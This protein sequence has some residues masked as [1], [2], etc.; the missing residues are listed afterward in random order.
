[1]AKTEGVYFF[2]GKIATLALDTQFDTELAKRYALG[3]KQVGGG[4]SPS[5]S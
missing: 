5:P 4:I 1:M 3:A 2:L